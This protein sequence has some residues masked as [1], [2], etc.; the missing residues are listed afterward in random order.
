MAADVVSGG[1]LAVQGVAGLAS[2][3][4]EPSLSSWAVCPFPGLSPLV[5]VTSL[6]LSAT[7]RKVTTGCLLSWWFSYLVALR[8]EGFPQKG[9]LVTA[10]ILGPTLFLIY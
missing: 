2:P 8:R 6:G 9:R 1:L 10:Q 7:D 3:R 4:H 5:S